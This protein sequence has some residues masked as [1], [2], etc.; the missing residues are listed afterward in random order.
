M[1]VENEIPKYKKKARKH[2]PK[3]ANH[4]HE[5][6][7]CVYEYEGFALGEASGMYKTLEKSIGTYCRI[8]GKIGDV[9]T[10]DP[11]WVL[12]SAVFN[13]GVAVGYK[14]NDEALAQM[15]P[16]TRTLPLFSI[17]NMWK[18]KNVYLED[19]H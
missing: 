9:H 12:N 13:R 4:E 18:V 14:Y 17:G 3:K 7:F 19:T 16:D 10:R 2:T 11:K 1:I 5:Y 15:N 6:A 8:C